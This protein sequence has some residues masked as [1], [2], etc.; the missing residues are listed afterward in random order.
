MVDLPIFHMV[1]VHSF[2]YVYQRV[3]ME[4]RGCPYDK[5]TNVAN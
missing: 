3:D 4:S 1:I 5:R 2:L